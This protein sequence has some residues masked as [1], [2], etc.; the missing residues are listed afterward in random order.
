M[1]EKLVDLNW[2]GE[3]AG[4]KQVEMKL[5]GV[6]HPKW[7]YERRVR[8]LAVAPDGKQNML[9]MEGYAP[10]LPGTNPPPA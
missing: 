8:V 2:E 3:W 10:P 7:P 1:P 4:A 5:V 6:L 9:L